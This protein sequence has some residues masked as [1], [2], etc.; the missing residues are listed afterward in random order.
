MFHIAR[1]VLFCGG[2]REFG[3]LRE[4]LD[5]EIRHIQSSEDPEMSIAA[6]EP[7]V[8]TAGLCGEVWGGR[9]VMKGVLVMGT[10][11]S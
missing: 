2:F 6:T 5:V 3:I 9:T 11:S 7:A 8:M 4:G 1:R 10:L